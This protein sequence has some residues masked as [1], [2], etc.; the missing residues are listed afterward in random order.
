MEMILGEEEVLALAESIVILYSGSEILNVPASTPVETVRSLV[1]W[2]TCGAP[3]KVS[4][5]VAATIYMPE[6]VRD[7]LS[8]KGD[9]K[10]SRGLR[11]LVESANVP[12]LEN[13]WLR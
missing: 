10:V 3:V 9:G 7:W 2:P 5:P 8:Q 13:A 11:K 12:E 6:A 4:N 1:Q